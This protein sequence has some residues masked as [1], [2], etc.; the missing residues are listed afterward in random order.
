MAPTAGMG[1]AATVA[2]VARV[3]LARPFHPV[4]LA[5][6]VAMVGLLTLETAVPVERVALAGLAGSVR[7]GPSR[8]PMVAM[9]AMAVP[10][11]LAAT[12]AFL[13]VRGLTVRTAAAAMAASLGLVATVLT[14]R[15]GPWA[16]Q[17]AL[18]GRVA[19]VAT[20]A[21]AVR[22]ALLVL[23][24]QRARMPLVATAG[25]AAMV[26]PG[27]LAKAATLAPLPA[28]TARMVKTA[29]MVVP[30]EPAVRLV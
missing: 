30:G 14:A 13:W 16:S 17:A 19:L 5:D 11:A 8:V 21:L 1:M 6:S 7:M 10:V 24:D 27:I 3:A 20:V 18:V 28:L 9:A 12:A 26:V 4:V 25:A 15:M 29:A 2:R 22:Q 23:A